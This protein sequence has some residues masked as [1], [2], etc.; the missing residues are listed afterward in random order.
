MPP[1]LPAAEC[2]HPCS[3]LGVSGEAV[4]GGADEDGEGDGMMVDEDG[5]EGVES[6]GKDDFDEEAVDVVNSPIVSI[7][8][9]SIDCHWIGRNR[10]S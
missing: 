10:S 2:F 5:E 1:K 7:D 3:F 8:C 6:V 4:E 9:R